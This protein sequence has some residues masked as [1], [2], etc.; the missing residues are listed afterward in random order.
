MLASVVVTALGGQ[1]AVAD[2]RRVKSCRPDSFFF[3]S[4]SQLDSL[5][6]RSFCETASR[7]EDVWHRFLPAASVEVPLH[8]E[9]L[10]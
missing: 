9:L 7:Q 5:Q 3:R 4:S 6:W 10:L 2:S 1:V 8:N